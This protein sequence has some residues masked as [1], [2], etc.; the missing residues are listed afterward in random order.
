M[1]EVVIVGGGL[2]AASTAESLREQGFVGD[3]VMV[4]GEAR[5]PYDRPPLSKEFLKDDM[6]ADDL[7]LH[8]Q[9]WYDEQKITVLQGV[10]ATGIDTTAQTVTTD[11]GQTLE[12]RKL[13]LATGS[14]PRR[15]TLDG[16]DLDNVVTLR[17]F[18][19]S[20]ALKEAL[21]RAEGMNVAVVGGG[22]IGLEVGSAFRAAGATVT[23][24][25]TQ[26]QPL[27][28]ALGSTM[29]SWFADFHRGHGVDVRTS[30]T[31]QGFKKVDDRTVGA[32]LL[33][34][35]SEVPADLVLVG[36]GA[37]PR[38]E[39]A[40]QAGLEVD[41]GV[42][43]D[44]H[45][46]SSNP[47]VFAT[48]DIASYPDPVLGR[49]RVEHWAQALNH[50]KA[51]ASAIAGKNEPYD[52]APFFY[53]DQ[54]ELGMEYAGHASPGDELVIRG[55]TDKVEFIAFW[56]RE[57]HVTAGMN[58]NIWDVNED[59]QKL[60]QDKVTVDERLTD[61]KIPLTKLG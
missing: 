10:T 11:D 49:L 12:Y 37:D 9:H 20:V 21:S 35:G 46:R 43:V 51:V 31:V 40:E 24:L 34:D 55:S 61:P 54:F 4:S 2:A 44:E 22:W 28:A 59:I 36:I 39:L 60:I 48:G 7:Q 33:G 6:P 56:V 14:E 50:P 1:A 17:T 41:N 27:L 8:T 52:K 23:V 16:A 25:E 58:V 29:G 26:E 18:E 57:G 5:L 53:S 32:V 42:V 3:I 45:G 38:V 13:V 19:E 47:D 30:T 15:L